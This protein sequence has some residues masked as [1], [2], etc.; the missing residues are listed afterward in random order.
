MSRIRRRAFA[1]CVAALLAAAAM[2][3]AGCGGDSSAT[4]SAKPETSRPVTLTVWSWAPETKTAARE[5]ERLHPNVT[6][7][8]VNAGIE[9]EEYTKL[10]AAL[11][12]GNGAP[13][14]AFM[15]YGVVPEFAIGRDLV[16]LSQYGGT[17]MAEGIAPFATQLLSSG[18]GGLYGLPSD[19]GLMGFIYREDLLKQA[20][21]APP[22]SWDEFATAAA[23]LQAAKPGTYLTN[24]PLGQFPWLQAMMWQAGS[25]PISV[26]GTTL[27]IHMD[28][29]PALR[30]AA[31]WDDLLKRHLVDPKAA[32]TTPYYAAIDRGDYAGWVAPVWG[33]VLIRPTSPTYGK[34][35]VAP[36]PRWSANDSV[37]LWGSSAYVITKD[38]KD[39]ATAADFIKTTT[40]DERTVKTIAAANPYAFWPSRAVYESSATLDRRLPFYGPQRA[41]R[42]W[43]KAAGQVDGSYQWSPFEDYVVTQ[44]N[45]L[46]GDAIKDGG[47]LVN[48]LHTL[49]S[50]VIAYAKQQGFTVT[51]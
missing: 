47:S 17:A 4:S 40:H 1:G 12:A 3:A 8:V 38:A 37:P 7:K 5:Y 32:F 29:A 27:T 36:L 20:G 43:A 25:R 50:R 45:Q 22:T 10:H 2:V 48:A 35:R 15:A 9:T 42:V 13:D 24:F 33:P 31:Y 23:R 18:G 34:W 30:V 46:V 41:N 26:N 11:Q 19:A 44:G 16:D 6:V 51:S 49:Q 14:V 21:I 39:A 28:D